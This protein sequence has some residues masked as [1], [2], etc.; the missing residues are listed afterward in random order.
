[1]TP[2]EISTQPSS[3]PS[4]T[5]TAT[6]IIAFLWNGIL[7][8]NQ[9]KTKS[10]EKLL[11]P[12]IA[13]E[14]I[15]SSVE[16]LWDWFPDHNPSYKSHFLEVLEREPSPDNHFIDEEYARLGACFRAIGVEVI[17]HDSDDMSI[18][19]DEKLEKH[20]YVQ[21]EYQYLNIPLPDHIPTTTLPPSNSTI[22]SMMSSLMRPHT[23]EMTKRLLKH[24]YNKL[25]DSKLDRMEYKTIESVLQAID[26]NVLRDIAVPKMCESIQI[27]YR[28]WLRC[29]EKDKT[30]KPLIAPTIRAY[31]M[32][33]STKRF[34]DASADNINRAFP[35]PH[36][37]SEIAR[38]TWVEEGE[39]IPSINVDGEHLISP[40]KQLPSPHDK[41]KRKIY[42]PHRAGKQRMQGVLFHSERLPPEIPIPLVA[43]EQF[44]SDLRNSLA[45][46]MSLILKLVYASNQPLQFTREEGAQFLARDQNGDFR[47]VYQTDIER[48]NN[49]YLGLRG[50]YIWLPGTDRWKTPTP[51]EVVDVHSTDAKTGK[52][53]IAQPKWWKR[54]D[55]HWTL[56]GGLN[57]AR[58]A[59]HAQNRLQRYI[60]GTEFWL[61][62]A[63]FPNSGKHK[64]IANTLIPDSNKTTGP[65]PWQPLDWRTFLTLGGDNWDFN[66]KVADNAANQ[67]W[68]RLRDLL[69]EHGYTIQ[70]K[71]LRSKSGDTVELVIKRG[72]LSVRATHRFTEAARKAIRKQW[73]IL[74]LNELCKP[75]K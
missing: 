17:R 43:Y 62:R 19:E 11:D 73:E 49:L 23:R 65:G 7:T 32:D 45:A 55:G 3:L 1:M 35:I 44:G 51:Y 28:F 39:G 6:E 42:R 30:L 8:A 53:Y 31:I 46:D 9:T 12:N 13:P 75:Q 60:D 22:V 40:I 70:G 66:D 50:I 56:T 20:R 16:A 37:I 64:G 47:R 27:L 61:A 67:R 72:G 10:I 4:E 71:R 38:N 33:K 18:S 24:D 2:A 63:K 41:H 48:F 57:P 54:A 36:V 59:G 58:L 26:T 5:A 74:P 15:P 21:S 25:T 68:K 34:S 29:Y 52:V 14:A 69:I